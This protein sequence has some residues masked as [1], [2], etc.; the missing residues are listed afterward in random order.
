MGDLN[1]RRARVLGMNPVEGGK[2]EVVADIPYT[3][4]DGYTTVLRSITGGEG[5]YKYEFARYEQ[6]PEDV[7]NH[8]IDAR[9]NKLVDIDA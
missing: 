4:L 6:A 5:V 2:Q 8:E 7:Q 1:K 9:K 3:E